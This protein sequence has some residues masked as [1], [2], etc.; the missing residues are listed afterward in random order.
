MHA[1]AYASCRPELS[2]RLT[3][4]K[5]DLAALSYFPGTSSGMMAHALARAVNWLKVGLHVCAC[6]CVHM[7][8]CAYVHVWEEYIEGGHGGEVQAGCFLQAMRLWSIPRCGLLCSGVHVHVTTAACMLAGR[9]ND[10][11]WHVHPLCVL[12][13]RHACTVRRALAYEY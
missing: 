8:M 6:A 3:A 12:Q 5:P 2:R 4:L 7:C 13:C 9:Q 11:L 1:Y 10:W